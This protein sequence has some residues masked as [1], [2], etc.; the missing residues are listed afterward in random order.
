MVIIC[1]FSS[2]L[3]KTITRRN[4]LV[5]IVKDLARSSDF[6]PVYGPLQG[7]VTHAST[8]TKKNP[9]E[10]VDF[11]LGRLLIG[12]LVAIVVSIR[13]VS[14]TFFEALSGSE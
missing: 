5:D 1:I 2:V 8:N 11:F 7:L 4:F 3:W 14:I 9:I 12:V 13:S 6:A 10:Y